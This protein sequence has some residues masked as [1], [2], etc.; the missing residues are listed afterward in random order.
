MWTEQPTPEHTVVMIY[1]CFENTVFVPFLSVLPNTVLQLSEKK[2]LFYL[3]NGTSSQQQL[4]HT[5]INI[6]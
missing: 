4:L 5:L 6:S 1:S 3:P 2:L